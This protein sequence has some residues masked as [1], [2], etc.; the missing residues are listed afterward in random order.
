MVTSFIDA[1]RSIIDSDG[2]DGVSI[3]KV[4]SK[5]GCSSAAL[6]LYFWDLNGL[7]ALSTITYLED[8]ART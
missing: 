8:A 5:V 6:Y 3:R 7:L 2:I 4:A 1:A